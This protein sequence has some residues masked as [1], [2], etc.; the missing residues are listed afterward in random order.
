[1][2]EEPPGVRDGD[3]A[4]VGNTPFLVFDRT[5]CRSRVLSGH[6]GG[7]KARLNAERSWLRSTGTLKCARSERV[8]CELSIGSGAGIKSTG[9]GFN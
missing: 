2:L 8:K 3:I 6:S 5:F 4:Y 1:M 7:R 9:T